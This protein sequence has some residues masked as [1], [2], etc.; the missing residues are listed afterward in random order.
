M[1]YDY[2]SMDIH[3]KTW[4]LYFVVELCMNLLDILAES[5]N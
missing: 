1:R 5:P 4:S 2:E 3:L